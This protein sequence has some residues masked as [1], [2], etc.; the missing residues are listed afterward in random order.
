MQKNAFL[1]GILMLISSFMPT[2]AQEQLAIERVVN[3]FLI[4]GTNGE[5]DRFRNAFVPDAVQRSIGSNGTVTGI[6]VRELSSRIKPN[7]VMDRTTKIVSWSYAGNAAT[8]ITETEY[9]TNKVIDMLNLLK[10]NGEWKIVSRVFTRIEKTDEVTSSQK[11]TAKPGA[12]P[13]IPPAKKPAPKRPAS[14]DGW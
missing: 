8:A 10:V 5:V 12:K 1:F 14:D 3:D 2:A 6:T 13:A 11:T 4:G 7:Q 9:P